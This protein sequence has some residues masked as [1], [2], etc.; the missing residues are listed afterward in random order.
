[1]FIQ[2]EALLGGGIE[3]L[4]LD[5]EFDFSQEELGGVFPFTTPVILKGEIRNTAGIV[6]IKAKADFSMEV[7]CDRCAEDI[8]PD[9]TVEIEHGLVASL[10]QE[11][12]DDYILIEDMKLDIRQLTLED[13]YLAL[14]GKFL[15]KED[16]KGLCS[17]CGA[18]LNEGS[19]NCKKPIDPRW[20]ALFD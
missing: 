9:F 14:P 2:L 13:I 6:T 15:C 10:N 19:C 11:D 1:M 5:Y 17:E 18:N 8:R 16:C 12:N 20:E 7:T 4:P 3:S